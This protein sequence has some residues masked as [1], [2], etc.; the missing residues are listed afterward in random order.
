MKQDL[1]SFRRN[2]QPRLNPGAA[3]AE[4]VLSV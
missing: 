2:V 3:E 1:G 4:R